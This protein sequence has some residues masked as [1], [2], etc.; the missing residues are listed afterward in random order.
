VIPLL[1]AVRLL[2]DETPEISSIEWS[3]EHDT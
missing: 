3:S 2:L 1:N